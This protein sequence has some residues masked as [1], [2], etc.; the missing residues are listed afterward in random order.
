M[1]LNDLIK[2]F[3]IRL[4]SR[5]EEYG[6]SSLRNFCSEHDLNYQVIAGARRRRQFPSLEDTVIMTDILNIDINTLIYGNGY[7][8]LKESQEE[9]EAK[10]RN[11]IRKQNII[12]S[13][14]SKADPIRIAAIEMFLGIYNENRD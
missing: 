2:S 8:E 10:K 5:I 6:Y 9:K 1:I 14:L 7:D 11:G 12:L 3:W 4:E 13:A